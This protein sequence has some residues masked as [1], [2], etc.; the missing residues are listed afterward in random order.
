M[1]SKILELEGTSTTDLDVFEYISK[2]FKFEN[3]EDL[4]KKLEKYLN[5]GCYFDKMKD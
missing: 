5:I 3:F 2:T 1:T 4:N